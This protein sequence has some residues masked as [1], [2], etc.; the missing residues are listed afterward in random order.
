M[1]IGITPGG[2]ISFKSPAAGDG[3][4]KSDSQITIESGLIDLLQDGDTVLADKGFSEI[5][6]TLDSAGKILSTYVERIM[7]RLRTYQIL[8]KIP[9]HLSDYIDIYMCCICSKF[10]TPHFYR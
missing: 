4:R 6:T 2:F 1:L 8:P 9:E 3:G 5:K 10:A 7:Q